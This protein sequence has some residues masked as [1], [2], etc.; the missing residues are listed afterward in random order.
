MAKTIL[1]KILDKIIKKDVFFTCGDMIEVLS[2]LE[3]LFF[4]YHFTLDY[5]CIWVLS[6]GL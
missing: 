6:F 5:Y 4:C 2:E 1:I 3:Y